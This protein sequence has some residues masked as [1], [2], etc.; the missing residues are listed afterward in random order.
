M[1]DRWRLRVAGIILLV[2]NSQR[3]LAVHGPSKHSACYAYFVKSGLLV[4]TANDTIIKDSDEALS[5]L[6]KR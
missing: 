2:S 4:G 5:V 1:N 6:E 3:I